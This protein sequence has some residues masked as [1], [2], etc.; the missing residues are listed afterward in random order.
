[1][2]GILSDLPEGYHA[3]PRGQ[4]WHARPT[5]SRDVA[6]G[7]RV[8]GLGTADGMPHRP[9]VQDH[10]C[11]QSRSKLLTRIRCLAAGTP[12]VRPRDRRTSPIY[13]GSR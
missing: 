2:Y 9:S 4:A 10:V 11:G 8:T 3:V 12:P 6:P 5:V 13:M 1:M 7:H